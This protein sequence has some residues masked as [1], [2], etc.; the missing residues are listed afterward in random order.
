MK[1]ILDVIQSRRTIRKYKTTEPDSDLIKNVLHAANMA[2]SAGNS[3]PWGFTVAKNE[4]RDQICQEFYNFAK[5]YIPT[6]DYIPVDKKQMMLAYAKDFGG[7]PFHIIVSYPDLEDD[8]KREEALKAT[9]AAI[10][11]I[12][13][14][15]SHNGLGTVWIGSRLNHSQKVKEIL[16][17]GSDRKIA[18]IIPIGYPDMVAAITPR[19]EIKSKTKWLGF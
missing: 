17:M 10:Q 18:G 4:Y 13:L 16:G 8:I 14:Q 7:A 11:N 12:L 3:Q 2:P 9:S 5:D 1:E 19:N 15:A 6:A